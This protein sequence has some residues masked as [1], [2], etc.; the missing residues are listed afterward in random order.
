MPLHSTD[1]PQTLM[2][3]PASFLPRNQHGMF[4]PGPGDYFRADRVL[5]TSRAE[6][7]CVLSLTPISAHMTD[8]ETGPKSHTGIWAQEPVVLLARMAGA[9]SLWVFWGIFL[10]TWCVGS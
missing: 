6:L 9:R 7:A 8:G 4:Q 5:G 3:K 1:W 2:A 10:A